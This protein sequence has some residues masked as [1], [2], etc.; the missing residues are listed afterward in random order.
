MGA[1]IETSVG[2]RSNSYDNAL[3]EIMNG[4]H[5]IELIH[6]GAS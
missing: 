6:R 1:G 5:K 4:L 3:V 2:S